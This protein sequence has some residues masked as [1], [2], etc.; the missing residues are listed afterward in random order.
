MM[1]ACPRCLSASDRPMYGLTSPDDPKVVMT[2]RALMRKCRSA[3][4]RVARTITGARVGGK[5][6]TYTRSGHWLDHDDDPER[7]PCAARHDHESPNDRRTCAGHAR[8][9]R[10]A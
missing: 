6:V 3:R 8:A 2:M 7:A 4:S 9:G 10:G 5:S 1:G